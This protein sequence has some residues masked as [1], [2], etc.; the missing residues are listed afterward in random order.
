MTYDPIIVNT[1]LIALVVI[2][3]DALLGIIRA[4]SRGEFDVRKLPQFLQS[5]VLPYAGS[6]V[7]L[8]VFSLW[9]SEI[10]VLLMACAGFTTAK[11]L[12]EIKDKLVAMGMAKSE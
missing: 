2:L 12:A 4:I 11:Y 7:V 1:V 6:L 5:S 3:A 8:A 10:K 9:V